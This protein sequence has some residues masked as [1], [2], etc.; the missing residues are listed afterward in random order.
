M[1][2]ENCLAPAKWHGSIL[3]AKENPAIHPDLQQE[4]D[5]K[6]PTIGEIK[7]LSRH[8]DT[9]ITREII[10]GSIPAD[11]KHAPVTVAAVT[12]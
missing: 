3:G 10:R 4:L 6:E 1:I 2:C 5:G 8:I 7:H 11:P 9:V 12:T